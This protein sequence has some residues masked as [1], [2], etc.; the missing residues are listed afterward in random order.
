MKKIIIS[1]LLAAN[2]FANQCTIYSNQVSTLVETEI[3]YLGNGLDT[4]F[5]ANYEMT[6][7]LLIATK[8]ICRNEP[9]L[10]DSINKVFEELN[11]VEYKIKCKLKGF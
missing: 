5:C 3:E 11:Q 1:S 4:Q 8:N 10:Y 9:K 7:S 6:L 2:L